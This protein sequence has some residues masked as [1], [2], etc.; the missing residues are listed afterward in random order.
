LNE[1]RLLLRFVDDL[2]ECRR[3]L[4]VVEIPA[5]QGEGRAELGKKDGGGRTDA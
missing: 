2:A 3:L 5:G 4:E 1:K